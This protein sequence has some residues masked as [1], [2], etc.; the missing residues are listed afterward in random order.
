[1]VDGNQSPRMRTR[2]Q[3]HVVQPWEELLDGATSGET[4]RDSEER[5]SVNQDTGERSA[6]LS[7]Q[8]ATG[9]LNMDEPV[10][11]VTDKR[12]RTLMA[13]TTTEKMRLDNAIRD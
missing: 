6:D 9:F 12:I 4:D 3:N 1:M 7:A 11:T 2:V 5:S 10:L 13:Q 8:Q